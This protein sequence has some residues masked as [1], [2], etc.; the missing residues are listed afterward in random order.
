MDHKKQMDR[1]NDHKTFLIVIAKQSEVSKAN[2]RQLGLTQYL[3][4]YH[5]NK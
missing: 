5:I 4:L 1:R 2:L 3:A